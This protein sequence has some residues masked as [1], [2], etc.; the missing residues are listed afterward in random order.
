MHCFEAGSPG[1]ASCGRAI[2]AQVGSVTKYDSRP[3]NY[4]EIRLNE[5]RLD[6]LGAS[7]GGNYQDLLKAAANEAG[8]NAFAVEFAGPTS[9]LIDKLGSPEVAP[10]RT[11][12]L[13]FPKLTRLATFI[14]PEEMTIDLT[15]IENDSLPDLPSE[16][17]AQAILECGIQRHTAYDAPVRLVLGDGRIIRFE[18]PANGGWCNGQATPALPAAI[19][20][21]PALEV[22]W[23]RDSDGEGSVRFDNRQKIAAALDAPEPGGQEP[24]RPRLCA[25]RRSRRAASAGGRGGGAGDACPAAAS[26]PSIAGSPLV[27]GAHQAL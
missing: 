5:A 12:F 13:R 23:S 6:W 8:G 27:S 17:A 18:A 26:S 14:S 3:E 21:L 19:S 2:A 22:G 20:G 4:F 7:P 24:R 9:A 16:H 10:L 25:R 11:L 15:V 1:H